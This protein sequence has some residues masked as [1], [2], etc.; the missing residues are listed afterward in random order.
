MK[1]KQN[2]LKSGLNIPKNHRLITFTLLELLSLIYDKGCNTTKFYSNSKKKQK[3]QNQKNPVN[4]YLFIDS[5]IT[6]F[7]L[8]HITTK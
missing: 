1:T 4:F 5:F 6:I 7:I 8:R 2:R 3:K